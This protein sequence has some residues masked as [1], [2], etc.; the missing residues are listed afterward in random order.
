MLCKAEP[1]ETTWMQVTG[2]QASFHVSS[3]IRGNDGEGKEGVTSELRL[4][5]SGTWR[6]LIGD[7]AH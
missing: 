7:D 6:A 2:G 1:F 4:D 3:K 5:V